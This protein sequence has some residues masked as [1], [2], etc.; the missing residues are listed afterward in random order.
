[1]NEREVM[2]GHFRDLAA[3]SYNNGVYTFSEFLGE[4]DLAVLMSIRNELGYAGMT[5]FG[6]TENSERCMV[7]FGKESELCYTEDFPISCLKAEPVSS[8]FAGQTGHRDYLG[9]LMGL[10]IERNLLGDIIIKEHTAYI[11]CLSRIAD[12]ICENLRQVRQTSIYVVRLDSVPED[13]GSVLKETLVTAASERLDA[14]IARLYNLSRNESQNLFAAGKVFVGG[15]PCENTG[16]QCRDGEKI[17]VRGY[18]KF[19]YR[20]LTGTTGKGRARILLEVYI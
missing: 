19:I 7:R 18:G 2:A 17:S 14:V 20:G 6:G 5:L 16:H 8:R 4:A 13:A 15:L 3:R 10:G 11:F 12:Y 9:A 1:M